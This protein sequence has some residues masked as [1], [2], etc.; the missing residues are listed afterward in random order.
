MTTRSRFLRRARRHVARMEAQGWTPLDDGLDPEVPDFVRWFG[1]GG[2]FA[3]VRHHY[4]RK[5]EKAFSNWLNK[6][7]DGKK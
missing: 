3:S 6:A 7:I 4:P 1:K 5:G 2:Q